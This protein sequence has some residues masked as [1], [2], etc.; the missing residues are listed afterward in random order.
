LTV[1]LGESTFL[2]RR[3]SDDLGVTL[4]LGTPD[5]VRWRLHEGWLFQR[6]DPAQRLYR[7]HDGNYFV[8][9]EFEQIDPLKRHRMG[10]QLADP[11]GPV[12]SF[13]ANFVPVQMDG[14]T[15]LIGA[16][17]FLTPELWGVGNT[18][19]WLHDGRAGTL[20]EAVLL[21]GEDDPPVAGEPDR[22]EA[23]DSRDAFAALSNEERE[24]LM[25]FLLSLRD[26][27]ETGAGRPFPNDIKIEASG[28]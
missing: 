8:V 9:G 28:M 15:V 14:E 16:A 10:R 20:A 11:A 6:L 3:R 12:P 18:G 23:Q 22:S 26:Y 21:H 24:S 17:V 25:T 7:R 13:T 19:P 1:L 27:V 4:G 2:S 5:L